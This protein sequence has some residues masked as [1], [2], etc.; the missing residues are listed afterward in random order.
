M[1]D[2]AILVEVE[3]VGSII[4]EA[5]GNIAHDIVLSSQLGLEVVGVLIGLAAGNNSG[6]SGIALVGGGAGSGHVH[7]LGQLGIMETLVADPVQDDVAGLEAV[8]LVGEGIVA[9]V[10]GVVSQGE[11][12]AGLGGV[13]NAVNV[14]VLD[15][16]DDLV[17]NIIHEDVGEHALASQIR[18]SVPSSVG[19]R[20]Q[21]N[22][23]PVGVTQDAIH[24]QIGNVVMHLALALFLQQ[25][26]EINSLGVGEV[27]SQSILGLPNHSALRIGVSPLSYGV[28]VAVGTDAD[29][30][31][32][33][34]GP[35]GDVADNNVAVQHP[36]VVLLLGISQSEVELAVLAD[37]HQPSIVGD[38]NNAIGDS[39]DNHGSL[40]SVEHHLSSFLTG[41]GLL[42]VVVSS[43]AGQQA[44]VL[45]IGQDVGLP[46][47][48]N[49]ALRLGI[50][51]DEAEE[52]LGGLNA[53]HLAIGIEGG[54]IAA[55][56]DAHLVAVSN[57]ALCPDS[58]AGHVG[59]LA[60]ASVEISD[61]VASISQDSNHLGHLGTGNGVGGSES[62]IGVAIQDADGGEHI[63]GFGIANLVGVGVL[64]GAGS[65]RDEAKQGS[66]DEHQ[67][68]NFAKVLHESSSL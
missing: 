17:V 34:V 45:G 53:G 5:I 67:S 22:A 12:V 25:G 40:Q 56:N 47:G 33:V 7:G 42:G 29:F 16:D 61:V 6:L 21:L 27:R 26:L 3:V 11:H 63:D 14:G 31:A 24:I 57:V 60:S 19:K 68:Q 10:V 50:E 54:G 4:F 18:Q 51:A 35:H 55:S 15:G 65:H 28:H 1:H 8:V 58:V 52:H 64:L 38:V 9:L 46:V 62:A 13:L 41:D 59:E 23:I 32:L 43:K 48:A 39:T 44:N 36:A 2:V 37:L 20:I 66:H 49:I 30:E